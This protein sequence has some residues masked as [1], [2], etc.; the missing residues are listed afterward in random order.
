[1]KTHRQK[2]F[3]MVELLV[4]LTVLSIIGLIAAL[5]MSNVIDHANIKDTQAI[6]QLFDVALDQYKTDMGIYPSTT[7]TDVANLLTDKSRGWARA[8]MNW[9]PK[10]AKIVDAWDNAF[11]YCS[12]MD[13]NTILTGYTSGRGV[14]R[15]PGMQNF[16]N[17]VTYQL[18]SMGPNMKTWPSK[19]SDNGHP[20]LCGT[21][22]DDIR[23]WKQDTFYTTRPTP[24]SS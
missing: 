24:Y 23:N 1:M 3:T 19:I 13:Y 11:G 21:E 22:P 18:Y 15:T 2:A 6:M 7:G 9:F 10:R 14:E 4:V 17:S 12:Y 20:R 8:S 16:Y 5:G